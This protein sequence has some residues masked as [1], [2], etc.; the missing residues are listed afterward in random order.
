L[1]V[2]DKFAQFYDLIYQKSVNYCGETDEFEALFEQFSSK[3][4]VRI[5]DIG[6]GTGSHSVLLSKR[7]YSVTGID[8]SKRMIQLAKKKALD[9]NLKAD[10]FVQD[11]RKLD[12][13]RRFDS[14]ICAFGGFGY[15]LSSRDLVKFLSRLKMHLK[16]EGTFL[17]EFWN[18]GGLKPSPLKGWLKAKT[19]ELVLYR[20]SESNFDPSTNILTIDFKFL[21]FHGRK[22]G[23]LFS[24]IH[25]IRCY[26]LPEI[27][28][29]LEDNAFKLVAAFDWNT[30]HLRE[31]KP[32]EKDSFRILVV[33]RRV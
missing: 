7:G 28:K 9:E 19:D 23:K 14:A 20:L 27:Q 5:L 1:S 10:F 13:G 11:M 6:C 33:A 32:F 18:V 15:L 30:Q 26:T 24:E 4:P 12:L 22:S 31:F 21:E 3:K 2:Y 25:K 17:F 16:R 29:Y 8:I